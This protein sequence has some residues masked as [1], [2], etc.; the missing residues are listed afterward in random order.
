MI[1]E[2]SENGLLAAVAAVA[3]AFGQWLRG[4]W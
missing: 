1:R 3:F 2:A 4:R